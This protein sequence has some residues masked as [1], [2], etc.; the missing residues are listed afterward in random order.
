[1]PATRGPALETVCPA[2]ENDPARPVTPPRNPEIR[3]QRLR[4]YCRHVRDTERG[5]PETTDYSPGAIGQ[6][7]AFDCGLGLG[8][9]FLE[10]GAELDDG[11]LDGPAGRGLM[12][13]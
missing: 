13:A 2:A 11:V 3:A 4:E 6:D 7:G 10:A 5:S 8:D 9:Q 12:L 1:M